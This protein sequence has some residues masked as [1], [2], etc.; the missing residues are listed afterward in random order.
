MPMEPQAEGEELCLGWDR[1]R[2]LSPSRN[3]HDVLLS[4]SS[5]RMIDG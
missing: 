5:G 2:G 1:I 4:S 3:D